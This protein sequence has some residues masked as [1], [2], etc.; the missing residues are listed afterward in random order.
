ITAL[1]AAV[2]R[3]TAH[4]VPDNFV[5]CRCSIEFVPEIFV[6]YLLFPSARFPGANP[7]GDSFTEILR[8]GETLHLTG[9]FNS[10]QPF[11]RSSQFHS[12]VCRGQFAAGKLLLRASVPEDGSPSSRTW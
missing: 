6:L 4:P 2:A 8:V 3:M 5:S 12:I 9:F 11:N 1:V 10:R 7:F